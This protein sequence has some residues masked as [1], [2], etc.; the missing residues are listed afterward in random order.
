ML[1]LFIWNAAYAITISKENIHITIINQSYVVYNVSIT[2]SGPV[3]D[4]ISYVFMDNIQRI[5]SA[6]INRT[7][8]NCSLKEIN[9][10]SEILCPSP[11]KGENVD[12]NVVFVSSTI[13]QKRSN[14][15]EF[16]FSKPILDLTKSLNVR[17]LLP[18]KS[19]I[20][21]SEIGNSI[22]PP[23]FRLGVDP[24]GRRIIVEW[25][26]NN[27][28]LGSREDFSVLFEMPEIYPRKVP[29]EER[30][31]KYYLGLSFALIV[32]ILII[33]FIFYRRKNESKIISVLKEDE[34]FVY[35]TIK[36]LGDGC[37]HKDVVRKTGFSKAKVSRI[38]L[39][40]QKRDLIRLKRVGKNTKIHLK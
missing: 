29:K 34:K 21:E 9:V 33:A 35:N 36:E 40:L 2:Y 7:T 38:L 14:I 5:L 15:Y 39:E 6:T 18:P 8:A 12:F 23:N 32:I 1:L 22:N 27:P 13:N 28:I 16:Y 3:K 26:I 25:N 17:V 30:Y 31:Y 11:I 24:S 19:F 20:A 10:G 4:K 37:K